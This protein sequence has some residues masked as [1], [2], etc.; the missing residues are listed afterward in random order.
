[1]NLKKIRRHY[2]CCVLVLFAFANTRAQDTIDLEE[3][4]VSNIFNYGLLIN[5]QT[6]ETVPKGLFELIIQH[7]FGKMDITNFNE[8][9]WD[10]FLGSFS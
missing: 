1:M 9:V 3:D 4:Y 7:R 10:E 2:C 5:T 8:T 6:T